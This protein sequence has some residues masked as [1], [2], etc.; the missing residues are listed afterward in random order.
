VHWA[1][2]ITSPISSSLRR[3]LDETAAYRRFQLQARVEQ[4]LPAG[5]RLAPSP[6]AKV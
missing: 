2:V 4:I 3:L 1:D 6:H 5:F